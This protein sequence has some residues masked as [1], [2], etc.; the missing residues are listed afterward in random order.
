AVLEPDKARHSAGGPVPAEGKKTLFARGAEF[1]AIDFGDTRRCKPPPG[2]P[3]EID[4]VLPVLPWRE[5]T[6]GSGVRV[7]EGLV[8]VLS[9]F[10]ATRSDARSDVGDE[11]TRGHAHGLHDVLDDSPCEPPPPGVGDPHAFA[12]AIAEQDRQ[13]VC[14]HHRADRARVPRYD[15][16]GFRIR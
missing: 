6:R 15:S 13:A 8:D 4:E 11:I 5:G 10:V 12:R 14:G 2:K 3:V 7:D 16:I 9:D 1:P